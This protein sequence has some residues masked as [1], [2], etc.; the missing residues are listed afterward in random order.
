MSGGAPD[1]PVHHSTQGKICLLSWSPTVPSCLGAIKGTP[2]CMEQK[3]QAF[4]KHLKTPRL[5][6]HAFGLLCY[7]FELLLSCELPVSCFELK[8]WLVCVCG[9]RIESCMCCFP[10]LLC[11]LCDHHC[12]GER[13]QFVEIPRK[14]EKTTEEDNCGTQ[15]WS[16][17][18]LRGIECNPWPKEVT[19][20]WK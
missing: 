8:S 4:S 9:L 10:S 7:W 19:T 2:R 5:C 17:D 6:L 16:L 11:F 18:D 3:H 14:R 20:T 1:C 15:S 12:K 13:L